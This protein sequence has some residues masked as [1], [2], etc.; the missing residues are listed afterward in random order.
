MAPNL[1]STLCIELL[2]L[3]TV[4]SVKL[5]RGGQE[6]ACVLLTEKI[7]LAWKELTI[8]KHCYFCLLELLLQSSSIEVYLF[9]S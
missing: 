4:M 8:P 2:L 6:D 1:S 3:F 5:V 7:A 9:C